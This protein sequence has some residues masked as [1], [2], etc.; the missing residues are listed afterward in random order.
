MLGLA[1]GGR[2]PPGAK[3]H[4]ALA[5]LPGPQLT[6]APEA[7]KHL[8][9]TVA[10]FLGRWRHGWHTAGASGT[11]AWRVKGSANPGHRGFSCLFCP[12]AVCG[13][14]GGRGDG[15]PGAT[16]WD[17]SLQ[18]KT[19]VQ[20]AR[21]T[22]RPGGPGDLSH[23]ASRLHETHPVGGKWAGPWLPQGRP[24]GTLGEVILE[25]MGG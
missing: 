22:W 10:P 2:A 20:S 18:S 19:G 9:L 23:E 16:L 8:V 7:T 6:R 14:R 5:R 12:A 17:L 3:S 1:E 13:G 24:L 15:E 21:G 25:P 11:N 4:L